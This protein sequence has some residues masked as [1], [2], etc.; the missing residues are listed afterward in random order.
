MVILRAKCRSRLDKANPVAKHREFNRRAR[1]LAITLALALPLMRI[2][3]VLGAEDDI[4]YRKSYYQE[5]DNRI[6]VSTDL[7]QFDYGLKDNVRVSGE[8]VVDAIS[9]ATPTGAPPQTHWP[10]ATFNSLYASAYQS[11]YNSIYSSVVNYPNNQLLLNANAITFQDL[12]NAAAGLARSSA[13]NLAT[14]TANSQLRQITSNRNYHNQNVPLTEMHDRR[15]AFSLQTPGPLAGIKSPL[16]SH[17]VA[18]VI[19]SRLEER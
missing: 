6:K 16:H 18:K 15:N 7:W 2:S 13:P 5:D 8:V 19:I 1:M 11:A 3:R 12:T 4:G 10:Y 17:I 9:G 14:N